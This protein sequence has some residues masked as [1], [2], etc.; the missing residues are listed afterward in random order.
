MKKNLKIFLISLL[1]V[2][3]VVQSANAESY[4]FIENLTSGTFI[5]SGASDASID[6][7]GGSVT[8]DDVSRWVTMDEATDGS[9][10]ISSDSGTSTS[11]KMTLDSQ[12]NPYVVW[13]DDT[14]GNYEV[15]ITRWNGSNWTQMDGVT[16]GYENVSNTSGGSGSPNLS[17]SLS[18]HPYIVW[19][20][21][22]AGNNE[23]FFTRWNGSAWTQMD[24]V[25]PGYENISN[26]GGYSATA[27]IV[28]NLSGNPYVVWHDNIGNYEIML[29]RWNGSAWTQMDGVTPGYEN[30]SNNSGYSA[31]AKINI[32][33]SGYPNIAWI[34]DYEGDDNAYFIRWNGSNWTQMDGVTLGDENVSNT[35]GAC[36]GVTFQLD[37][38]NNPYV[39]WV[40]ETSGNR[41]I[42]LSRWNGSA[43][44]QV[45]G[46]TLG[47]ENISN[48][49]IGFSFLASVEL[50]SS[51]NPY[52]AWADTGFGAFDIF[53][54]R[55]NGSAWTQM[56]G[57]TLGLENI[58]NGNGTS[59][60]ANLKFDLSGNLL[61]FWNGNAPGNYEIFLSKYIDD[62]TSP[63][64]I[65][66]TKINGSVT[67]IEKAT[68]TAIDSTPGASSIAY[69]LSN[70]GGLT[71]NEVSSGVEY[72]FSS[73][74][75]DLRWKAVLY[76]GSTP[77][78]S[79]VSISYSEEEEEQEDLE[80][81]FES[82]KKVKETSLELRIEV[83][84]YQD[85]RLTSRLM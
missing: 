47:Y 3:C 31:A 80:I 44:T 6:Y 10:N 81:D 45:D 52:I 40:D 34:D 76:E 74:G 48:T 75:D 61:A 83:E 12:G 55:W 13:Q 11:P 62:Y 32:D 29:T 4:S 67:S 69:Y 26:T 22:T 54:T 15:Y 21:D 85:E 9:E 27:G 18:D 56:D 37:T 8:L 43:W 5:D 36:Y 24:G 51:N 42:Y 68:L 25:T 30:I 49:A 20:D 7:S 53:I 70:D 71:W 59:G 35:T 17:M 64:T 84:N 79:S 2:F 82:I 66:S 1:S 57:E 28:T 46:V 78:L 39:S 63:Q 23:I 38:S 14:S 60:N 33:S 19:S 50:D 77:T 16:P 73:T 72:T 41:E 58:T 65:Q